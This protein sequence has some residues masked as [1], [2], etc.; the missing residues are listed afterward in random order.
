MLQSAYILQSA[1]RDEVVAKGLPAFDAESEEAH[2]AAYLHVPLAALAEGALAGSVRALKAS[3]SPCL[4]A[5][6][7]RD[8]P[9]SLHAAYCA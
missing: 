7:N 1:E 9:R 8:L 5:P 2:L 4:R 3:A 6:G